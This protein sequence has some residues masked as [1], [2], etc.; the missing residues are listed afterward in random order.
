MI[1]AQ[2]TDMID[3]LV[4]IAGGSFISFPGTVH[5]ILQALLIQQDS[6]GPGFTD[7]SIG[8][9]ESEFGMIA[10]LTHEWQ[11]GLY[12]ILAMI[13]LVGDI[14]DIFPGFCSV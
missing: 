12:L 10:G 8:V 11:E 9:N 4:G 13:N 2:G 6:I 14:D 5:I 3:Q 7:D 1:T